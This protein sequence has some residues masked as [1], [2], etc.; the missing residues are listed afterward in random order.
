MA[1]HE[2]L[3]KAFDSAINSSVPGAE[4]AESRA[5]KAIGYLGKAIVNLDRTSERLSYVNIGLGVAI[6]IAALVQICLM[7]HAK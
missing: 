5:T 1:K 3:E 4:T 6:L 7:L 2:D